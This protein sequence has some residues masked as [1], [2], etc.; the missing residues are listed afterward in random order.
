MFELAQR[1]ELLKFE[2]IKEFQKRGV[3]HEV[4]IR[5]FPGPRSF[6]E[7]HYGKRFRHGMW[8]REP[9]HIKLGNWRERKSI[10]K[11]L[12][13][14]HMRMIRLPWATLKEE[15][16]ISQEM[17]SIAQQNARCHRDENNF[18]AELR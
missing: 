16:A 6:L 17:A 9:I 7:I 15:T 12:R 14:I 5:A 1:A 11:L 8:W 2:A 13:R 3:L 4:R 18:I 10:A